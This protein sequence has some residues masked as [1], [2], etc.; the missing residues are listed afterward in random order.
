MTGQD[1]REKPLVEDV[2]AITPAP[3]E[4][5]AFFWEAARQEKLM[6]LQCDKCGYYVHWP[7]SVCK[8]CLSFQL[9]PSEV[10]GRG[11]VYTYAVGVQAFHPWFEGRLPYLLAV[12]ELEEQPN[13][14]LVTNLVECTE[15][16]AHINMPVEVT[17]E[18]VNAEMTL[19][20]FRPIRVA[21]VKDE[22]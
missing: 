22:A 4:E 20:M 2:T 9:T 11:V 6:I 12:V 7:R 13:L 3:D 10:S 16:D 17:Y 14:R 15:E 19:P 1:E 21:S 18:H 8:R 5:T